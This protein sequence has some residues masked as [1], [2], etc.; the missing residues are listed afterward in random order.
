M[1]RQQTLCGQSLGDDATRCGVRSKAL[2]RASMRSQQESRF[3]LT[4]G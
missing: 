4:R 1:M 2:Q 3:A